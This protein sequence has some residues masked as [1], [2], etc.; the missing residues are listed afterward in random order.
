M[1]AIWL[2]LI[3]AVLAIGAGIVYV[4]R[5]TTSRGKSHAVG[6][7]HGD[8]RLLAS[9]IDHS[10]ATNATLNGSALYRQLARF[11]EPRAR[12]ERHKRTWVDAERITD[13]WLN[14]IVFTGIV[15]GNKADCFLRSHGPNGIDE[16]GAGD[17]IWYRFEVL[18]R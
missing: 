18:L 4:Q 6:R 5:I 13:S 3:L 8:L 9:A 1:K 10:I 16:L 11:D 15:T 2:L 7:T 12:I 14:D 17:D